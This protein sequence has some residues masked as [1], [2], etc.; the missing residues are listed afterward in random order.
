M[1]K[2]IENFDSSIS[3]E[4][5]PTSLKLKPS[6]RKLEIGIKTISETINAVI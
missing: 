5:L 4:G 2:S 6:I 1:E 3:R